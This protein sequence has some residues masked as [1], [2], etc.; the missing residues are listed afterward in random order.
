MDVG[1]FGCLTAAYVVYVA[2]LASIRPRDVRLAPVAAL[3]VAIQLAPVA[4]PLML[5][6]DAWVYWDY[7][8]VAAVHHG[9][10]Y[11][12][13]PARYSADPAFGHVPDAWRETTSVYGPAFTLASEPVALAAGGSPAAA[14]WIYKA[15]GALAVLAAT[16]CAA[17]VARRSVFA[18]AFIGWNPLLAVHFGGGGHNDA[19]AVALVSGALA[20]E[21]A[22]RPVAAGATWAGTVAIKWLPLVLLPI[23]YLAGA[24][25]DP[26]RLPSALRRRRRIRPC[27]EP[28]LRAALAQRVGSDRA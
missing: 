5:S 11:V 7:G 10:P 17:L 8:R 27:C 2:G 26:L 1:F 14:A 13:P 16:A 18:V 6:A 12:D 24:A 3:A 20:L 28:G 21:Q 22:R 23:H 25:G 15:L 4:A 19:A 9:N